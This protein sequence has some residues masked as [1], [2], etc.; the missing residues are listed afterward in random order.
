MGPLVPHVISSEFNF[1][2]AF[3]I[4]IGFGFL[5]E[6]AGFSSTR[7]LVGLFYGYDFTV[8]RVFFTAG[9][10]A[11]IGILLLAHFDQLDLSLIYVNPTFLWSALIGGGIM[12]AGF[13]I[14]GFC[15]GT[16]VCAAATGKLDA[17]AFIFGSLLGIVI[18]TEGYPLFEHLFL[19]ADMGP[20]RID[21][22]FGL[23]PELLS[24]LMTLIAIAAFFGVTLLE[25][26]INHR[27]NIFNKRGIARYAILT[28]IPFTVIS[29]IA[30]TPN[31][32]ESLHRKVA[33]AREQEKCA[34]HEIAADKLVYEL[35]NNYYTINLIDV[36]SPEKYNE[37]HLPLAINI[38]LEEMMEHR[39]AG[40]FDQNYK[41]NVF[42]ADEDTT[43][44][45]ACL[46]SKV[47]GDSEHYVLS[48]TMPEFRETF[49]NLQP[50][51]IP[52]TKQE[53]ETYQFRSKA[54]LELISLDN[55]LSK[56]TQP[57]EKE[58]RRIQGGCS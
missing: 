24:A 7:K 44:K 12:G 27:P 45:K 8:L 28:A 37:Y 16:S 34:I 47:I 40:Y 29:F 26:R 4:G 17:M 50:P 18:F 9:I 32:I 55:A 14:G 20:V 6:Q 30:F 36:R 39:W 2:I 5:L 25:N 13:I 23:S 21:Q 22:Y 10:T 41:T 42:Y 1:V 51:P 46:L 49:F 3:L 15:P 19:A 35:I 31:R 33:R 56:F 58:V 54:A 53:M 48:L 57:V 43:A 38:P 52:S 11:M